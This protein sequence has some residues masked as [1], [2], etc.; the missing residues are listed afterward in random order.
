MGHTHIYINLQEIERRKFATIKK[1]ILNLKNRKEIF[2]LIKHKIDEKRY[3]FM[4]Y[5]VKSL[6]SIFVKIFN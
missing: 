6:V 4:T 5:L 3:V 1:M 2:S